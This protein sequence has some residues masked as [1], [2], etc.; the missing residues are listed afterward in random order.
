MSMSGTLL[1][2]RQPRARSLRNS[3][4][5]KFRRNLRF[6]IGFRQ[7]RRLIT[8]FL[9]IGRFHVKNLQTLLRI[10]KSKILI[11]RKVEK[12]LY[13]NLTVNWNLRCL[14]N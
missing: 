13:L 3:Q 10:Q 4:K 9:R 12:S 8:S 2:R 5:G 11:N 14:K 6:L 1:H 7:N